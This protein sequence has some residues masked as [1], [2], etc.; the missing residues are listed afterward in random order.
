MPQGL[1]GADVVSEAE[2]A[3]AD[4]EP[5]SSLQL[6]EA[7]SAEKSYDAS[8][9]HTRW[10]R[11]P[12]SNPSS[13]MEVSGPALAEEC[14]IGFGFGDA[15]L[16]GGSVNRDDED[17]FDG[18]AAAPPSRARQC[19]SDLL[20][21]LCTS[22]SFRGL[23]GGEGM[24]MHNLCSWLEVAGT[25]LKPEHGRRAMSFS[26][27]TTSTG[28]TP[29]RRA[30]RSPSFKSEMP[31]EHSSPTTSRRAPTAA[32]AV[33]PIPIPVPFHNIV[34][35]SRTTSTT[36]T[37]FLQPIAAPGLPSNSF[38]STQIAASAIPLQPKLLRTMLGFKSPATLLHWISA[39]LVRM[40]QMSACLLMR[41]SGVWL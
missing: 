36:S 11:S 35:L 34:N 22:A 7:S 37:E 15:C 41:G 33:A 20:H 10:V 1:S 28:R 21:D 27:A 25:D 4:S 14:D 16:A 39:N 6:T 29:G 12:L 40:L 30:M 2:E 24:S 32:A 5:A 17:D 19:G 3:D 13:D 8:Y 23:R 9:G 26:T 38:P 18:I 31:C